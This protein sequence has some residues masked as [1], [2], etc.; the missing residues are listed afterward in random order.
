MRDLEEAFNSP[1]RYGEGLD[2]S[3][4]TIHDCASLLLRYLMRLP[5]P[6]ICF[7]WYDRFRNPLQDWAQNDSEH[8]TWPEHCL[9][10]YGDLI[11]QLPPLE[12]HCLLYVLD[13]IATFSSKSN[14]M[15]TQNLATLFQP[16]LLSH[17]SHD[18]NPIET[19]LSRIVLIFLIQHQDRYT[20][21]ES[22]QE[23]LAT[24][25]RSKSV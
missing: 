16:C 17:P 1:P 2:W 25:K 20:L 10:T 4:Y 12:R 13:L 18:L 6:L 9:A 23:P 11:S 24:I 15:T 8:E 14:K 21:K 5:E 7:R 3:G 22:R 19:R